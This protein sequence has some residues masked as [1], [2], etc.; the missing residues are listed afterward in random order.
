M[1]VSISVK[2]EISQLEEL[3]QQASQGINSVPAP[4]PLTPQTA[5][6]LQVIRDHALA[7]VRELAIPT[8]RDEEWRFT[9]LSPLLRVKFHSSSPV[10][11]APEKLEP[12]LLPEANETRLVF[13]NGNYAPALSSLTGVPG[14][15]FIGSLAQLPAPQLEQLETYLAKQPGQEEVFTALNTATIQDVAVIWV[16]KNIAVNTPIHLLLISTLGSVPVITQPRCLIVA[17][18]GSALNLVEHYA[19]TKIS[20]LM[21]CPDNP[22]A[23]SYFTNTVTE[24][25]VG[26]NAQVEHT[27]LQRDAGTAFHIGK[28]AVS[29][30]RHS[31][32][33]CHSISLGAKLSRHHLE[34]YQT[35]EGTETTL[36]GLTLISRQQLADTHSGIFLNHPHGTTR[37][38]HKCIIDDQARGVFNGKILVPQP[39]Q[40]TDASQLS[41]NLLLSTKARVDTKPQLEITADNV[42]CSHGATVSQLDDDELFYLQS[43]GLDL[44]TSRHLLIDAFAAEILNQLPLSSL[45]QMLTRCVACRT[46]EV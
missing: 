12:F 21:G 40:L 46:L 7:W 6:R 29:Q 8:K 33:T 3:L 17:E 45:Q 44:D 34:I 36:N 20:G 24:I 27:R 32:Y 9:D 28:T 1:S 25:W 2:P 39:A 30:K 37:Q 22:A 43:R 14:G 16:N 13:V 15:V 38:L 5:N 4:F 42:K 41:R 10:D 23:Q 26:E 19:T 31:R 35:G 18:A 11:L